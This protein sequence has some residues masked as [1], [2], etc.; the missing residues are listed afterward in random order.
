MKA[1]IWGGRGSIPASYSQELIKR[2]IK[3]VLQKAVEEKITNE[4][5]IDAFMDSLP[6]ALKSSYGSNTSC[7]QITGGDEV[8]ICDAGSGIRDLG[9]KL[10]RMGGDMPKKINIIMSHLHWDHIQ[11]FPF[12]IP[13]YFQGVSINVYG[14][15]K[16]IED[17]FIRQQNVPTFPV[18]LLDMGSEI[19]FHLW[20][21]NKSYN[22]GGIELEII[23]QPH[24]GLSYGY[25]FTKSG[26]SIVYS[27]DAEHTEESQN[28]DYPFLK[29]I[30]D[31]EVL[32]FDGQFTL[33][34]HM[35]TKQNWGHS[36][37][38]IGIEMA[39]RAGV[40]KLC[41]FHSDHTFDDFQLDNFLKNS[42]RYKEIYNDAANLEI[43]IAYDGLELDVG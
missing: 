33:A 14:C 25:K 42:N 36:S 16:T 37:N 7:V 21:K 20:D 23:E 8:I 31:A 27:T 34:D 28:E 15:H 40:K 5:Q 2:K 1:I 32:I 11:G 17:T 35:F 41:L 30:A 19:N 24:P 3:T 18:E 38:L 29:F 10:V 9:T 39:I 26:K 12:F 43:M 4:N 22:L 13:A 6:F